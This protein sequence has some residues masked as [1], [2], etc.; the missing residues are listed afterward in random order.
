MNQIPLEDK[1]LNTRSQKIFTAGTSVLN[2][3]SKINYA[4]TP[5][6][7]W[8]EAYREDVRHQQEGGGEWHIILCK[9]TITLNNIIK[10][11]APSTR[12]LSSR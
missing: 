12:H 4:A 5:V 10:F 7:S 6:E 2:P 8:T 9:E 1:F 11:P 3:Q